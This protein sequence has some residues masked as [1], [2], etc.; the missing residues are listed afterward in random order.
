LFDTLATGAEWNEPPGFNTQFVS[1]AYPAGAR[2]QSITDVVVP[3]V[4]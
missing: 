3:V 2:V 4:H 1:Y